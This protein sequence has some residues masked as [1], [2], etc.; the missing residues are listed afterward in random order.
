MD[1]Y[2]PESERWFWIGIGHE[3]CIACDKR[4]YWHG[5]DDY[6]SE[7]WHPPI[8]KYSSFIDVCHRAC[9]PLFYG[10]IQR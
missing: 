5:S 1:F 8:D 2:S 4:Y 6:K 7:L 9:R 3:M 10:D